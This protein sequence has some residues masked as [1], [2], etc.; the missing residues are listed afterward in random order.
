M[1]PCVSPSGS[2]QGR[3]WYGSRR[4]SWASSLHLSCLN[5]SCSHLMS[6]ASWDFFPLVYLLLSE[7]VESGF[8]ESENSET[9]THY[10]IWLCKGEKLYKDVSHV[11]KE[12]YLIGCILSSCWFGEARLAACGWSFLFFLGSECIDSGLGLGL[13][14]QTAKALEPPQPHGL[15]I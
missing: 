13:W 4:E 11:F 14:V 9:S 3:G 6:F 7:S 12:N 10:F 5:Q 15:L 8:K 1:L 2:P